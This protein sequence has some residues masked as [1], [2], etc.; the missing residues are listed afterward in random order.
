MFRFLTQKKKKCLDFPFLFQHWTQG[1]VGP[2]WGQKFLAC[3]LYLSPPPNFLEFTQI[4]CSLAPFFSYWRSWMSKIYESLFIEDGDIIW[5]LKIGYADKFF[6]EVGISPSLDLWSCSRTI[7][8]HFW[9]YFIFIQEPV[10][11]AGVGRLR[12]CTNL[13][14]WS[15]LEIGLYDLVDDMLTR[16]STDQSLEYLVVLIVNSFYLLGILWVLS[17]LLLFRAVWLIPSFEIVG[18]LVFGGLVISNFL[19]LAIQDWIWTLEFNS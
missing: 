9:S 18:S 17:V 15:I 3:F 5:A 16:K 19:Y 1:C 7:F 8:F 14:C 6:I 4:L 13:F 2:S 10:R 11:I 12:S